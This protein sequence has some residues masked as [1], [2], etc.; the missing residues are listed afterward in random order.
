MSRTRTDDEPTG[1]V[2]R[3]RRRCHG[4]DPPVNDTPISG[5]TQASFERHEGDTAGP[6]RMLK[7]R[8]E[9]PAELDPATTREIAEGSVC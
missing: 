9:L 1:A 3:R 5:K 8:P 2:G 4:F 6:A 7:E